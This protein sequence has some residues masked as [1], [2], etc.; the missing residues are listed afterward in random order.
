MRDASANYTIV[1]YLLV[2]SSVSHGR[3]CGEHQFS[4]VFLA[5]YITS[6]NNVGYEN[7]DFT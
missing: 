3:F 2:D 4:L 6:R 1:D 7:S 5:T